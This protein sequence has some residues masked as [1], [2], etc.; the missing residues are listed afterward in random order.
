ME[1]E[2]FEPEIIAKKKPA[3]IE[4]VVEVED[5]KETTKENSEETED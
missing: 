4:E 3:I 2:L 5:K 1:K